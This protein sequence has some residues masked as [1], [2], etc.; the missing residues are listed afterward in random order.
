[1]KI[2][3]PLPLRIFFVIGSMMWTSVASAADLDNCHKTSQALKEAAHLRTLPL[4]SPVDCR[5]LDK[6]AYRELL[7]QLVRKDMT[8]RITTSEAVIFKLIGLIP[9]TYPYQRCIID[10]LT[11]EGAAFYWA[12][13]KTIVVP[14]WFP[15]PYY[16]LLHE[17]VHALQDQHFGLSTI[18]EGKSIFSDESLAMSALIEGD[19]MIIE[20]RYLKSLSDPMPTEDLKDENKLSPLDSQ[21][22]LPD[23]LKSLF[24]F[25]YSFGSIF[26][27]RLMKTNGH[28]SVNKAFVVWPH[29][30]KEI[31]HSGQYPTGTK[32]PSEDRFLLPHSEEK[33][34]FILQYQERF[35]QYILQTLF[36]HWLGNSRGIKAAVGWEDDQIALFR[37]ADSSL[38]PTLAV[39]WMT[40]WSSKQ[41]MREAREAFE[42]LMEKVKPPGS[43]K[44]T[45]DEVSFSVKMEIIST[46]R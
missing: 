41:D 10:N 26:V 6:E 12:R 15:T 28:A 23:L 46:Q 34:K 37:T 36:K 39:V 33:K 13:E 42:D 18:N 20:D 8:A 45:E 32:Q 25:Q 11:E 38:Q 1:M 7:A 19:A 2:T 27:S 29:T 31:I 30:T 22:A 44:I 14:R 16:I 17:A 9:P 35:G 5:T 4:L 3:L 43:I 40:R 24:Q 21:C